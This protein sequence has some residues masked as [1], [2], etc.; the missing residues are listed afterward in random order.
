MKTKILTAISAVTLAAF[1]LTAGEA[2]LSP[3]AKDNQITVVPRS[4]NG[5]NLATANRDQI[6]SPRALANENAAV[7]G[8]E[9][10]SNPAKCAVVGTPRQADMFASCCK[11]AKASCTSAKACCA[12]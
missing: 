5:V 1:T 10:A 4:A 3:R 7:G 11:V 8:T 6:G 12:K 9:T 2:L